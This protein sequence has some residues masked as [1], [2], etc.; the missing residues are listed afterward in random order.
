M[1]YKIVNRH[2]IRV[3]HNRRQLI[4][5]TDEDEL[6]RGIN[7]PNNGRLQHL[8]AFVHYAHVQRPFGQHWVSGAEARHRQ[9]QLKTNWFNNPVIKHQNNPHL[10][11]V[12]SLKFLGSCTVLGEGVF[13]VRLQL[14]VY[15]GRRAEPHELHPEGE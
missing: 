3:L 12:H 14:R 6:L 9:H 15:S 8:R 11:V 5:I 13:G 2:G 7:G 1:G 10:V 4:R